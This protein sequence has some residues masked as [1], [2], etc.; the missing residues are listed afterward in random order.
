MGDT[1]RHDGTLTVGLLADPGVPERVATN[2]AGDLAERA[3]QESGRRWHV[4][5][6]EETLPLAPDGNIH[7]AKYAPELR[8]RYG[9]DYVVYLTDLPRYVDQH[10]MLCQVSAEARA[11]LISL[12]PLGS[13]RLAA[14]TRDLVMVLLREATA[15]AAESPPTAAVDSALG[16]VDVQEMPSS[17][18]DSSTLVLVGWYAPMRMLS[19]MLRSNRPGSL[20]P[21]LK[22]SIAAAVATGAFGI[23]YG[24]IAPLADALAPWRLVIISVLVIG[25]LSA[26]LII[27]NRLWNPGRDSAG[28]WRHFLDNTSTI[29]TVG[30]SVLLMYVILVAVMLTMSLVIVEAGYLE[31]QVMRPVGFEQYFDLAWLAASLGTMAG[32]L[33]SSFDSDEAVRAATYSQR[34]YERR[35]MFGGW[36]D[37]K[38]D[39]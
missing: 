8:Q 37:R 11:T 15:G 3:F 18:E 28:T 2:I 36:Q 26:W 25:A 29:I 14:R 16:G 38:E 20:L 33:G 22:G 17:D 13:V 32:A 9:W 4:E 1:D 10:P 39:S 6:S 35:K 5:V 31:S 19:G 24:T 23:F 7:L 21:A 34:Y 30:V 12:P 27:S